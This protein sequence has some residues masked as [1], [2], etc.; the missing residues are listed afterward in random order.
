[1]KITLLTGRTSDLQEQILQQLHLKIKIIRSSQA[2]R[3]TL[4]IDSKEHLR[5]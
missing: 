4:R 5:F 3:L 1:M 2:K